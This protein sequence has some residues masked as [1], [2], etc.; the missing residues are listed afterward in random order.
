MNMFFTGASIH[1]KLAMLILSACLCALVLAC[2]GFGVYER[3]NFRSAAAS[4]LSILADTLGAN[5]AASLAFD[6]QKSAAEMLG[7]LRADHQILGACLYDNRGQIFAE[8]RRAN[9][10]R[11][12]KMPAWRTD[13]A[14]FESDSLT[15][16][17]SVLLNRDRTGS[18]AIISDLSGFRGRI[19]EYG[20]IAILVLLISIVATYLVST[21]FL[22]VI[23]EPMLHLAEVAERIS[24]GENYALRATPRG[25]DEVGRVIRS[26]NQML[27]RIEERDTAI[28]AA[29]DQLELRVQE[30]T[31]ALGKEIAE[32]KQAEVEMRLARDA[33]EEASRAKSE[34]VANMSHEIRTPL[35]GVVG[36][37]ELAL[38]TNLSG[39]QRGYLE[40]VKTSADLLLCVINNVLDFSKIEAGKIDLEN[41]DFNLFDCL[42]TTLKTMALRADEKGLELLC[43]I[44]PDVPQMVRGDSSRLCQIVINLVSNAIKFTQQGEVAV[45]VAIE[46]E[47][48]GDGLLRFTVSDTGSGIP[49]E[50]QRLIFDPF[51]QADTSTTRRYGGTG[52]G[53]TISARLVAMMGGR[54]WLES[55]AGQGAQFHFTVRFDQPTEKVDVITSKIVPGAKVLVVDDNRTNRQILA[56]MLNDWGMDALTVEGG[57][58]ALAALDVA[59]QNG[60][61]YALL[62]LD[63]HMP[64]MDGFALIEQVRRTP[65]LCPQ[66][67][68]MLTSARQRGDVSRCRELGVAVSLLKPIRQ[69]ELRD[70]VSRVLGRVEEPV[71]LPASIHRLRANSEK[72]LRVLVAEDNVVNQKVITG[73]L[74]KRG[75]SVAVRENGKQV[76]EALERDHYDLILMDVQMPEM[77]G[78]EA[79]AAIREKEMLTGRHQPIVALTAHATKGDQERCLAAGMDE[80]L[81]KPIRQHEL[82]GVLTLWST[83]IIDSR[84]TAG[85]G[86]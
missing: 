5:T 31:E 23:T 70:A 37:T 3:A 40:T 11:D 21:R 63:L 36:M 79:T 39:E 48:A 86:R 7:A 76:L 49:E 69:S 22:R 17:K 81:T 2:A 8:Y 58:E 62:L 75:H 18:I 77:D 32:R 78:I 50:K 45:R 35:N 53:L 42:E 60:E 71:K 1:R 74:E 59:R 61:P 47:E 25:R 65:G 30:R 84:R 57:R 19:Q 72:V 85:K 56:G 68:M 33:A 29:R 64:D 26:F 46:G 52:L 12:F 38:D 20:K 24:T 67:I 66:A 80:C 10:N 14:R 41:I 51:S 83:A 82:D 43:Q 44:D 4:E 55:E 54:I 6:D 73:L 28:Q 34:F 15:L 9:L 13:G 27:E 16:F